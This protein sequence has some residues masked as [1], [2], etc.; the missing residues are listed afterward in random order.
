MSAI[1]ERTM[2]SERPGRIGHPPPEV[3]K[4]PYMRVV[5]W[6]ED[7]SHA[8]G[9]APE[10]KHV[11][12]PTVHRLLAEGGPILVGQANQV[13]WSFLILLECRG[14]NVVVLAPDGT[15]TALPIDTVEAELANERSGQARLLAFYNSLDLP[16]PAR[17][18]AETVLGNTLERE[19]IVFSFEP[20]QMDFKARFLAAGG[21]RSIFNTGLFFFAGYALLIGSWWLMGKAAMEG[22]LDMGW[23]AAWAILLQSF[24]LARSAGMWN[25][26]KLAIQIGG[27]AR[28]RLL[29]GILRMSAEEVRVRGIGN[30]LGKVLDAEALDSLA[31]TGGPTLVSDIFQ[32]GFGLIVLC[33]GAVPITHAVLLCIWLGVAAILIHRLYKRFGDWVEA[34]LLLT[35]ELVETMVGYRTLLAQLPPKERDPG[36]DHGLAAY[37]HREEAL[38]RSM[39]FLG[40][41]L[42]RGWL[43]LAILALVPTFTLSQVSSPAMAV[44]LGGVLLI[45]LAFRRIATETG[46]GIATALVAWRNTQKLFTFTKPLRVSIENVATLPADDPRGEV[47]KRPIM[48]A[49][50]LAFQYPKRLDPVLRGCDFEI[51]RGDRILI[52]GKSGSGKSTLASMITG[53][54]QPSSGLLLFDGF[55]QYSLRP[56]RWRQRAASVPQGHENYILSA[57]LLFNIAMARRWPPTAEDVHEIETICQELGLADL[58]KRMPGGLEQMVGDSGWQLSHG[59]RARV[60]VARALAQPADIRVLDESF[61]ALDPKTFDKVLE[62]ILARSETLLVVTHA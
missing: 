45:Y 43:I 23:F 28:E 61:A 4:A 17:L 5:R 32:V 25:A 9:L 41:L 15:E 44:S 56:E 33:M 26:G 36:H 11:V 58:L 60:Y 29:E 20:A 19:L 10:T 40:T 21:A 39:T 52:L 8:L 27:L 37:A 48:T 7:A 2:P 3:E 62:C 47:S 50:D 31:R 46:P 34:R 24:A 51:Y 1:A 42:H 49:R 57:S 55:D 59:E 18:S 12:S 54:R 35:D 16:G 13:G 6:I 30:L 14:E 22:H 53:L 38:D